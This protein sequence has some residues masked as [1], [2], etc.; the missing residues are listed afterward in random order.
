MFVSFSFEGHHLIC[1]TLRLLE[2][3]KVGCEKIGRV[4]A[5]ASS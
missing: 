2:V 1:W 5:R 3:P 4:S